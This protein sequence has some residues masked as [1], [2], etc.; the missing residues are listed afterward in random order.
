MDLAFVIVAG[1][2]QHWHAAGTR[3]ALH[4]TALDDAHK[5]AA[6]DNAGDDDDDDD[7]E[8]RAGSEVGTRRT[9]R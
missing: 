6:D 2:T 4:G 7:A 9:W 1:T 8:A 5:D 3:L